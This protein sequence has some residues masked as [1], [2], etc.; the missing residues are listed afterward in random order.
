MPVFF[1]GLF[2][3][4]GNLVKSQIGFWITAALVSFGLHL[5]ANEFVLDPILSQIQAATGG[6]G[7]EGMA[8]FSYLAIDEF[9]TAT[10]SAYAVASSF[11]GIR[12]ARKAT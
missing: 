11:S 6:I 2:A 5:V 9:I 4:L 1:A 7:A 10:L 12:M 8:W 3:L